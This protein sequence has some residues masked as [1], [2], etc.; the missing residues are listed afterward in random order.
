MRINAILEGELLKRI[1]RAAGEMG[2]SRSFFIREA[3][4]RYLAAYE[5]QKREEERRRKFEAAANVQDE[6]REKGGA[7]DGVAEIRKA[8]EER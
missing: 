4:E 2:K 8:R 6:L 5:E 3:S 1:D 7:W